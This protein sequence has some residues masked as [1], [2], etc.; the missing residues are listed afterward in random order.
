MTFAQNKNLS[1]YIFIEN[2]QS[3]RGEQ[4]LNKNAFYRLFIMKKLQ[5]FLLLFVL[6]IMRQ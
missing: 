4:N 5:I 1:T 3:N 2:K 6:K